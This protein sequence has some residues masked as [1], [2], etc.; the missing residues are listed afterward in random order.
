MRGYDNLLIE[1]PNWRVEDFQKTMEIEKLLEKI[2]NFKDDYP[3]VDSF[4]EKIR[5]FLNKN[6]IIANEYIK[7]LNDNIRIL[8]LKG[9]QLP[10]L[11][12][13]ILNKKDLRELNLENNNLISLNIQDSEL[14]LGFFKKLQIINLSDNKFYEFPSILS[15]LPKLTNLN[16]SKN[17]FLSINVEQADSEDLVEEMILDAMN[18]LGAN[19]GKRRS[20]KIIELLDKGKVEASLEL[21]KLSSDELGENEIEFKDRVTLLSSRYYSFSNSK[22]LGQNQDI[23]SP[24]INII[25]QLILDCAHDLPS[26]KN[27]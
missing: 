11:P 8:D 7:S 21:L 14:N 5:I 25:R 3:F 17:E 10:I 1:F 18:N 6:L 15:V 27:I 13:E 16:L 22:K 9:Y 12:N 4:A 2:E 23:D 24:F 26:L 19:D 20:T